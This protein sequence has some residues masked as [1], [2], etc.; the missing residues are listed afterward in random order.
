MYKAIREVDPNPAHPVCAG[1]G[2]AGSVI[3]VA[4]GVCD[5]MMIYW[6]PVSTSKYDRERTAQEVQHMLAT[7]R[8]RVPG[9]PFMGIYHAFDG[10]PAKTG[11]GVPTPDQLREQLE[12]FVREGACGLVSFICHNEQVPGWADI[13]P[14]GGAVT[15]AMH[16]IQQTGGLQLRP[17]TESMKLKR[18]QPEGYWE[19]PLPLPGYV[20]AWYVLAPFQGSEDRMLDTPIPPEQG[21]DLGGVYPVKSGTAGWR[22]RETTTGTFGINEIYGAVKNGLAYAFCDVTIAEEMPVQMRICT[23]DDAW[24]RLNGKEVYRFTGGRGLDIDKDIVPLTLPRGTSRIEVKSHNRAGMWGFFMRFTDM[25]GR[26]VEGLS[27]APA[28]DAG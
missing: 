8:R 12:D 18:I 1:F 6:Y 16:E 21:I 15:Q 25:E 3:N 22:V 17:E 24:V 13:E 9:I 14:L 10:R 11:Q 27:F 5:I 23:D 20:P 2:D 28:M 7:A 4:P 26:P 19:K